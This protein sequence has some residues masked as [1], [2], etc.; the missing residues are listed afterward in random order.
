MQTL[1]IAED[2]RAI[3][4]ALKET[5]E[6][7]D[8]MVIEAVLGSRLLEILDSYPVDGII[9]N[10]DLP[11]VN[12]LELLEPIRRHTNVPIIV[13]SDEHDV[14]ETVSGF[15]RGADDFLIK[16]FDMQELVARINAHLKRYRQ[17]ITRNDN[18]PSVRAGGLDVVIGP[19]V[20][21]E[22][23]YDVFRDDGEAA[24]LTI[25]EFRLLKALVHQAGQPVNR[26][27]LSHAVKMENYCPTPRAIDIKITRIRKKMGDDGQHPQLIK[28]VRGVGYMVDAISLT[29][30]IMDD[31]ALEA[32]FKRSGG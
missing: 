3:R 22:T 12:G 11:D 20:L 15:E 17:L 14:A 25:H 26:D 18:M 24:G 30:D 21:D 32:L 5:L 10:K 27:A 23:R 19:W 2:E 6:E 28:T 4:Y 1:L 29:A 8:Y 13:I 9:L 16:P 7:Q 31:A